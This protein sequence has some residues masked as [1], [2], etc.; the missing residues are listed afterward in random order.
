[1]P[2]HPGNLSVCRSIYLNYLLLLISSLGVMG[3]ISPSWT[4]CRIPGLM[5][6]Q[7]IQSLGGA[8]PQRGSGVKQR[9]MGGSESWATEQGIGNCALLSNPMA[10]KLCRLSISY[11]CVCVSLNKAF[12][13][14]KI[15][16]QIII[17]KE[18]KLYMH[19]QGRNNLH[20]LLLFGGFVQRP[21]HRNIIFG[22]C[23]LQVTCCSS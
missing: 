14:L 15:M 8:D 23:L 22:S 18:P 4:M 11:V 1:M 17:I 12:T 7:D 9:K 16:H 20:S 19:V 6:S 5:R 10:F 21:L 2:C 3:K 13:S